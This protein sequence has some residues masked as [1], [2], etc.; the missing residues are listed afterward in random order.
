MRNEKTRSP[1]TT[2]E[3]KPCACGTRPCGGTT[4]A[5]CQGPVTS[6]RACSYHA[7]LAQE[8]GAFVRW[9]ESAMRGES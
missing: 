5:W 6:W 8:R 2:E 4:I 7:W 1:K 3:M 9:D